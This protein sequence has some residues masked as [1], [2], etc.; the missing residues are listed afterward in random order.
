MSVEHN[1]FAVLPFLYI[2]IGLKV[3]YSNSGVVPEARE[4]SDFGREV[5]LNGRQ[6]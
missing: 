3:G 2:D 5:N 4:L 1:A 6:N